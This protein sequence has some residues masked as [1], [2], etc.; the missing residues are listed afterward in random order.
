MIIKRKK[1]AIAKDFWVMDEF[2]IF[3]CEDF[4]YNKS[5]ENLA[6]LKYLKVVN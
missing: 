1:F 4:L 3:K 2:L 6:N 5:G